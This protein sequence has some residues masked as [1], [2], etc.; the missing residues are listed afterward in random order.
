M[1]TVDHDLWSAVAPGRCGSLSRALRPAQW[2]RIAVGRCS[3]ALPSAMGGLT[4]GW[5][6]SPSWE[7]P[8]RVWS[9]RYAS[10][11]AIW[12]VDGDCKQHRAVIYYGHR[13]AWAWPGVR[14]ALAMLCTVDGARDEQARASERHAG[15]PSLV[16]TVLW[17]RACRGD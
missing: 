11:S 5:L 4:T 3:D 6:R 14:G 13:D 16:S 17:G 8:P 2:M 1:G 9:P 7:A 10:P 15:L 12:G